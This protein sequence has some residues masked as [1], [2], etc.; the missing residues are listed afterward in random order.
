MKTRTL[1]S[2]SELVQ[3]AGDGI[4]QLNAYF[5]R[6][7]PQVFNTL[8]VPPTIFIVLC[9]FNWVVAVVLL[10]CVPLIPLSILVIRKMPKGQSRDYQQVNVKGWLWRG[11]WYARASWYFSMSRPAMWID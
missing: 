2:T 4:D 7:I 10:A 5:G 8:L 6:Y 3:T 9:T 11:C 1:F